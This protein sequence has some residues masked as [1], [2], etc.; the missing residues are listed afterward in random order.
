[1]WGPGPCEIAYNVSRD[2]YGLAL[3]PFHQGDREISGEVLDK[4]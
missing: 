3:L 4:F 2:P 1:M